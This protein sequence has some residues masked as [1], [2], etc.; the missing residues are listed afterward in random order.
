M[1]VFLIPAGGS[2]YELYCEVGDEP[3]PAEHGPSS[4]WV[5]RLSDRFTAIVRSVEAARHG[6][7]DRRA[8]KQRRTL[9]RRIRDR[10][11]CWL[12][13]KIA[14]QRL[15]W[16]LRRERQVTA[17][18]PDDV[19]EKQATD[20]V[21]Q[22]LAADADRHLRWLLVDS[23]G[24]VA[25]V[26]LVPLPGPN[27]VFYYFTFRVVGHCLSWRGARHGLDHVDW[28]MHPTAAL[29][30]LREAI[31]LDPDARRRRVAEIASR[32]Q[33]QHLAAFFERIA[34]PRP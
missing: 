20:R 16:Y 11:V 29:T 3:A 10:V 32:L 14:E 9:A 31:A 7:A 25:S 13:E 24:L 19:G 28:R 4:G 8:T 5:R 30:D 23:V 26:M 18:F 1:D 2:R 22:M 33:L 21:R 34:V 15:L 27:L 12:A 17:W 6:A